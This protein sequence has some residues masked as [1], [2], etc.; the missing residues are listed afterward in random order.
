MATIEFT[1]LDLWRLQ[2]SSKLKHLPFFAKTMAWKMAGANI[3]SS[4]ES[5]KAIVINEFSTFKLFM[6]QNFVGN[7]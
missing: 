5:Q 4:Q 2:I 3:G 7:G 1:A 6:M